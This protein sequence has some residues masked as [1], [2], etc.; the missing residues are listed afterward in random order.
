MLPLFTFPFPSVIL[1]GAPEQCSLH[2]IL[3]REAKDPENLS[4]AMQHQGVLTMHY[5]LRASAAV[6]CRLKQIFAEEIY[7]AAHGVQL[8]QAV[9][10]VPLLSID[11]DLAGHAVLFQTP[12]K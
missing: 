5:L 9:K 11:F 7:D 8:G 10:D 3:Q 4:S 12:L 1:N 6:S 2:S